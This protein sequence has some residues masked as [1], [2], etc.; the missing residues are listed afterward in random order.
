MYSYVANG[1]ANR[2]RGTR[3]LTQLLKKGEDTRR[4]IFPFPALQ[5][6]NL[7]SYEYALLRWQQAIKS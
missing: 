6:S 2:E 3:K 4:K 1:A 7:I 5:F